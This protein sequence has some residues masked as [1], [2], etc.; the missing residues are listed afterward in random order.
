MC[1]VSLLIG[2]S[3]INKKEM[4]GGVKM[5]GLKLLIVVAHVFM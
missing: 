3:Q 5:N 1:W 2:V 4:K